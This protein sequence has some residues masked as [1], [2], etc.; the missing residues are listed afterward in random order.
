MSLKVNMVDSIFSE[1]TL[2]TPI[3]KERKTSKFF[4][5]NRNSIDRKISLQIEDNFENS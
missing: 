4:E 5:E 3:I 2:A 1:N